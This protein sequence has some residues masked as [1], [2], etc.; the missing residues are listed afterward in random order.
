MLNIYLYNLKFELSGIFTDS[1]T[2]HKF[3]TVPEC[4]TLQN[5]SNDNAYCLSWALSASWF[6]LLVV[7][8]HI[9]ITSAFLTVISCPRNLYV[10]PHQLP[11]SVR[12]AES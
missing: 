12:K 3:Q 1:A 11:L 9:R 2:E 5:P 8:A 10:G 4:L 7:V 6:A